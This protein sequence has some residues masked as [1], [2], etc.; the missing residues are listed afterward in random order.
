MLTPDDIKLLKARYKQALSYRDQEWRNEWLD[1][2]KYL[3]PKMGRFWDRTEKR[4][5]EGG[6][7]RKAIINSIGTKAR[8]IAVAGLKGGM[9]P[10]SLPWIKL[11]LFDPDLEKWEPVREW[12]AL[13]TRMIL[14]MLG[15]TNFY[16]AIMNVYAEEM[17]FGTGAWK[18]IEHPDKIVHFKPWT[19]G[20][21]LLVQD[22]YGEVTTAFREWPMR[23]A[24]AAKLYGE[25]RLSVSRRGVLKTNP[26]A[27]MMVVKAIFPRDD[28]KR[29]GLI[30]PK[31]M[32]WA[33][34]MWE[35]GAEEGQLLKESGFETKPFMTPRWDTVEED[36][37]GS[38]CLGMEVLPDVKMLQKLELEKLL[39]VEKINAPP[40][41]VPPGFK[42]RLS[43]DARAKN[44]MPSGSGNAKIEPTI[45]MQHGVRDLREEIRDV[46]QRIKDGYFNDLFLM[47]I[48]EDK[49]MTATEVIRRHEEKLSL[50]GPVIE[51]QSDELLTPSLARTYQIMARSGRLPMPP[52]ELRDKDL[53]IEYIG[54]LAQAQK[55]VGTNAVERGLDFVGRVA[56]V[57]YRSTGQY[58]EILDKVDFDSAL[59][60][61][62]DKIGWGPENIRSTDDANRRR[63]N[64]SQ[65]QQGA[66]QA[67]QAGQMAD[68]A[69]K[70]N[71]I[72]VDP[73]KKTA[74]T[75]ALK[76]L[77]AQ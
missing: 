11:G 63:Q 8:K 45:N 7:D 27:Y 30:G 22:D 34:V 74:L 51:R 67:E 31:G 47:F 18:I 21:Y 76:R 64:R 72:D 28:I 59:D 24:D 49:Q 35:D 57:Q 66:M 29:A 62:A 71:Q 55:A 50:L 19:I 32:K 48:G 12:L 36:P 14:S 23:I 60:D 33:C 4:P 1:I 73:N 5:A 56:D 39:G 44:E 69:G 53:R 54:L 40:M 13:S 6:S 38:D 2:R 58:P 9:T 37:Y 20:S 10:R 46:E 15:S 42:G 17:T 26:D 65:A 43:L 52:K 16:S 75:E 77:P 61:Y 3:A 41:N 25:N 68:V 70:L